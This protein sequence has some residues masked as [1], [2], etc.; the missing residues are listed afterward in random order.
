MLL[1]PVRTF[2]AQSLALTALTVGLFAAV[3]V[4]GGIL[5]GVIPTTMSRCLLVLVS[6]G[7]PIRVRNSSARRAWKASGIECEATGDDG[8]QLPVAVQ[9]ALGWAVREAAT[10]VLGHGDPRLCTIRLSASAD[11]VVLN[12]EN[13]GAPCTAAGESGSGPAG[14]RKRLGVPGASPDA[15]PA[16]DGLFRLTAKVSLTRGEARPAILEGWR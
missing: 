1:A 12:V 3:G 9:S 4:P 5:A 7:R 11:R 16:G 2:L 14:L 15:G 8:G 13:D 6:T 10:H